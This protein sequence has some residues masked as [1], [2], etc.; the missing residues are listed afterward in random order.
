MILVF[1]HIKILS[2]VL[3]FSCLVNLRF[4]LKTQ[5]LDEMFKRKEKVEE[6]GGLRRRWVN[7]N[8]RRGWP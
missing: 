4:K 7:A 6:E 5:N 2:K 8:V 3:I 1:V